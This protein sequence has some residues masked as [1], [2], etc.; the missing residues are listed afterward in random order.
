[1]ELVEMRETDPDTH[2]NLKKL[3]RTPTFS[4]LVQEK[5]YEG[6]SKLVIVQ[7]WTTQLYLKKLHKIIY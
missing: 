7:F 3:A 6:K 5:I 1:M 4:E 2:V